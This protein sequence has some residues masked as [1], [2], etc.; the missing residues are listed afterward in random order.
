MIK[1]ERNNLDEIANE[2]WEQMEQIINKDFKGDTACHTYYL[3][4]KKEFILCGIN[5]FEKMEQDFKRACND[6]IEITYNA[7]EHYKNY[8]K[9]YKED[10]KDKAYTEERNRLKT[11][12]SKT[13]YMRFC[14]SMKEMY[15][16]S[17]QKSVAFMKN[18]SDINLGF[19]LAQELDIR[20]CPYCNRAYTFTVRAKGTT[21]PEFD[22]FLP[23]SKF[24]YFALSFYNLVPSCLVCNHLKGDKI[25]NIHPY[26]K[27]FGNDYKFQL[28]PLEI[29]I[30]NEVSEVK[31][32]PDQNNKNIG[33]F[34]LN[35]LYKNHLDYINEIVNKAKA[36]N[37]D[38]YDSLIDSFHQLGARPSEINRYIWGCYL[39]VAEQ[40]KRPLSKLTK[41]IL[42]QLDIDIL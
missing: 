3:A 5:N 36:Y 33:V 37:A 6:E 38:Y 42:D 12:I 28:D 4:H 17:F 29:M 24:P 16:K 18:G 8:M 15:E 27:E 13:P 11:K 1:I 7:T 23:K 30:E 32:K 39:D 20:T 14:Q 22:H 34:M 25:I 26:E 31:I 21:R 2:Y 35:E 19:W 10:K 41:D 40:N 9:T